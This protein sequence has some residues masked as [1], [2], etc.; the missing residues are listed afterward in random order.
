MNSFESLRYDGSLVT[1]GFS[2]PSR[3]FDR[4]S[5]TALTLDT[6]D[7]SLI[8]F[9]CI[10]LRKYNCDVLKFGGGM[11]KST[12]DNGIHFCLLSESRN[13]LTKWYTSLVISL[14]NF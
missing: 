4:F 8:G 12:K 5:V 2:H 10:F 6:M 11:Q 9:L 7:L 14:V 1:R 13:F 3:K